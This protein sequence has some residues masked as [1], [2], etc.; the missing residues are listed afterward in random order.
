[1]K[2]EARGKKGMSEGKENKKTHRQ[3]NKNKE[4]KDEIRY[5]EVM[6]TNQAFKSQSTRNRNKMPGERKKK[7]LRK[8][9]NEGWGESEH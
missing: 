2:I 8:Q 5:A 4:N 6:G 3:L 7:D 1:M 9:R